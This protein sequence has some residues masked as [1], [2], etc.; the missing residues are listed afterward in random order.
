M[1]DVSG[2]FILDNIYSLTYNRN[3]RRKLPELAMFVKDNPHSSLS[4]SSTALT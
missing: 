1:R 2:S 4:T 3:E